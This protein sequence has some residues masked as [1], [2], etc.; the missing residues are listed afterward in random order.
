M[1]LITLF[2]GYFLFAQTNAEGLEMP[3]LLAYSAQDETVVVRWRD[4]RQL[5][6]LNKPNSDLVVRAVDPQKVII[7]LRTD[8]GSQTLIFEVSGNPPPWIPTA[9]ISDTPE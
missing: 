8:S 7:N 1:D 6:E 5:L 3:S 4:Q 9:I 2:S